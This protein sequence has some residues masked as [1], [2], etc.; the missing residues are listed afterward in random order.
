MIS[1]LKH[2]KVL[3][4]MDVRWGYNNIQ[5]QEGDKWKAAFHTKQGLFEPTVMFF[6]LTNSPATFQAFI[7]EIFKDLIQEEVVKVYMDNI[8]VFT[9]TGGTLRSQ[10]KSVPDP[11]G[12]QV[13]LKGS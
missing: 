3:S 6:R 11:A 8:L 9:D 4:K 1:G 5:I 2:S 10:L 7:N 13:V 12:K